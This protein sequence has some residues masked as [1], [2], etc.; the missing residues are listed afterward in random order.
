VLRRGRTVEGNANDL[1]RRPARDVVAQDDI[2]PNQ[3]GNQYQ[4]PPTFGVFVNRPEPGTQVWRI[5]AHVDD[6]S[7][8]AVYP[9][10]RHPSVPDMTKHI[11]HELADHEYDRV[12]GEVVQTQH[13]A[14]STY[15][16]PGQRGCAVRHRQFNEGGRRRPGGAFGHGAL[17]LL[18]GA[19]GKATSLRYVILSTQAVTYS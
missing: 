17:P 5:V 2:L 8:V 18:N 9:C 12:G 7:L 16:L 13:R 4:P 10:Q 19:Q 1:P 15:V 14:H 3:R 6:Q 11:R